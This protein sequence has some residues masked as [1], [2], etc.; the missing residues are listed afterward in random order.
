MIKV[1]Y[2]LNHAGKAGTERYVQTLIEKLHNNKIKAYFAYNED[3]LLVERL[4]EL[5]IETYRIEMR[6][7][8]DI[9]AVFNLVKL[10]FKGKLH[11]FIMRNNLP[12][13]I[14]NRIITPLESNNMMISNGINP[15]KIKVIFNGVD[16]KYWSEPVESTVREEFQIDDDVFVMLCASRFL[17]NALYELKKMTNRKFKCILSNDGPLLEECKK[18]VEDM[19][20]SDVVIFAGFRKDS[21]HEAF[22]IIEVLAC[23]VPLIATDMGGNR[24]IINKETNCGI[25]VQYKKVLPRP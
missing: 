8:F 18:Q 24:D 13:R 6:N 22:L 4:K 14:A 1:L 17:I 16:V 11:S 2:L 12:I 3:G 23:G 7:P 9:K 10:F 5:G 21:E 25:L 15:K 19:G 20:L